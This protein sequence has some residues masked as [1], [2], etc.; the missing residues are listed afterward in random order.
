MRS[1]LTFLLAMGFVACVDPVEGVLLGTVDVLVVDGIINN[2]AEP[3]VIRLNRSKS[4]PFTGQTGFTAITKATVEVVVDS[5]EAIPCHETVDGSYQLP[6]DFKGQIGHTYQVRFSLSDGTRYES[7]QQVMP[8]YPVPS[9]N[10]ITARFNPKSLAQPMDGF[11]T[12]GHDVF[13]EFKDPAEAHNYYRW[14]WKLWEKQEWCRTCQQ[15]VYSIYGVRDSLVLSNASRGNY[16]IY[17]EDKSKLLEDCYRELTPPAFS[18][19]TPLPDYAY[20]YMCRTNCWEIFYS[21]DITVFDDVYTNGGLITGLRAAQ[22]P[23]YTYNASLVEI[24]QSSLT[25][26]AYRY[27]KVIQDQTQRT[28]GLADTPPSVLA[29][30]VH[31]V[32]NSREVVVGFFTASVLNSQRYWLDRKDASGVSLGGSGPAGYGGSLGS[33]LFYVL[34]RRQPA[35]EPILPAI[36]QMIIQNSLN[37]PPTALCLPSDTRTPNKPDGWRD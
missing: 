10:K 31:N 34:N 15:G 20:D 19:R 14:D 36:P 27:F 8:A 18:Y 23:L 3:Q 11:F 35:A 16:Y 12:A 21:H 13:V 4:D 26:E 6:S 30:N 22:I 28:G 37:R 5:A 9:I 24:R 2:Q 25:A 1:F 33:E 32:A 7:S 29:G 17:T